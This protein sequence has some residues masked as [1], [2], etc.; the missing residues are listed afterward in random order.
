MASPL[1]MTTTKKQKKRGFR[2]RWKVRRDQLGELKFI[3]IKDESSV[4]TGG[5]IF[6]T[7]TLKMIQDD[8]KEEVIDAMKQIREA[9]GIVTQVRGRRL[10]VEVEG[11]RIDEVGDV[12]ESFGC[13]WELN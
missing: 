3:P 13:Q 5:T 11:N 10:H 1:S 12:L 7:M 2:M 8:D 4:K 9:G 6:A